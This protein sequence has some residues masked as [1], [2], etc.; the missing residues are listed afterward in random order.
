M[1]SNLFEITTTICQLLQHKLLFV[2]HNSP[3]LSFSFRTSINE[4]S[5]VI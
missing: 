3:H 2:F 5:N 4:Q 1:A